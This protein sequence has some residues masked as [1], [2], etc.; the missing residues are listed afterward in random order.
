MKPDPISSGDTALGRNLVP[1]TPRA[2]D[3]LVVISS[4]YG[5]DTTQSLLALATYLCWREGRR[6]VDHD[7]LTAAATLQRIVEQSS[8]QP[9][10]PQPTEK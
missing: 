4:I 1:I 9:H 8:Q 6:F 7:A 5:M 10:T 2:N 3:A